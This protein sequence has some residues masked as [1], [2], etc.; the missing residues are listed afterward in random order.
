[1]A[2]KKLIPMTQFIL[3]ID[4]MT[5]KEFCEEFKVPLPTVTGG[6]NDFLQIDAIKQKI[7]VEYAKFLNMDLREDM[8]IGENPIF[9]NFVKC[10]QN[11]AL[12]RG[13]KMS[14]DDF[15]KNEFM[16]RLFQENRQVGDNTNNTLVT[17][18]H[19]K[20]VEHLSTFGLLYNKHN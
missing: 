13:I 11:E 6:A 9:P 20:K 5:T 18:F 3:D 4:W 10:S 16:M 19:L 17:H 12:K 2:A 7:F 14:F 8:F 15:G 1:M